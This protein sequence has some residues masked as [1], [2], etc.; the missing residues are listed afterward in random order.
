LIDL[1]GALVVILGGL[2]FSRAQDSIFGT[3]AFDNQNTEIR[4]DNTSFDKK[5]SEFM[6]FGNVRIVSKFKNGE[7][8]EAFGNFAKYN[9]QT[10]KGKIWGKGTMIKYFVKTSTRPVI[11]CAGEIQFDKTNGNIRAYKDVFVKTSSGIITSDNVV[12]DKKTSEAVFEKGKKRP[13]ADVMYDSRKQTYEADKMIFYD[14]PGVKKMFMEGS[15]KGKIE[16]E[17]VEND[18]EN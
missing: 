11:V 18:I 17:D 14:G 8:V 3:K 2:A 13:V 10:E 5:R 9:T 7:R 1:A 12:F 16:M 4:A 15:V 6:A